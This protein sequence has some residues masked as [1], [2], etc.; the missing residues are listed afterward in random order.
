[1]TPEQVE[2]KAQNLLNRGQ[3]R[4]EIK[5]QLFDYLMLNKEKSIGE[6]QKALNIKRSTFNYWI[7][8]FEKGGWIKRKR[9]EDQQ[10]RP[11]ILVLNKAKIKEREQY[12]SKHWE[13]FEE[14]QLK[15][16][17]VDK[18][19]REIEENPQSH[20]QLQKI[21]HLFKQD[22]SYGAK[23]IFLLYTDYIKVDYKFLITEKGKKVLKKIK[24]KK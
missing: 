8:F 17:F 10:G 3:R 12:S 14:Y 15:S 4:D 1:M 24:G 7:K 9:F 20:Q 5:R 2:A 6:V 13:S 16:M 19:L 11:T 23:C 22:S 18:I 21:M